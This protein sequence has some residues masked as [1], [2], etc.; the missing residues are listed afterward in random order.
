MLM[1]SVFENVREGFEQLADR[2]WPE[3]TT[4]HPGGPLAWKQFEALLGE[5]A[6]EL[7]LPVDS[8]LA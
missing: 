5:P 6:G 4:S 7:G 2:A 3:S 8:P 1:L